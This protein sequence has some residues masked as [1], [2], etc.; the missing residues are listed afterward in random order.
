MRF[1]LPDLIDGSLSSLIDETR[2]YYA[3]RPSGSGPRSLTELTEVR[4]QREA[5]LP[6]P[7]PGVYTLDVRADG[8]SVSVRVIEPSS[9]VVNGIFLHIH[10][11]GFYL[12]SA[13]RD[14]VR[15]REFA[16]GAGMVVVSVDYRLAPEAPWPAAPDDCETAARWLLD[17]AERRFG[18]NQLAIGGFSAGATL[19]VVT[20]LRLRDRG[21][22][23]HFTSATLQ[24]GTYDL[25]GTTPAGRLIADEYFLEAYIG[26]VDDRTHPDISPVFADLAG[27]PSTLIVVGE[28]DVLLEDNLAFATRLAAANNDVDLRVYP[29]A[30]HGFSVHPTAMAAAARR[31]IADW[32]GLPRAMPAAAPA[33]E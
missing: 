18:T 1:G 12:D 30:P 8:H 11:G 21:I 15:N 33:P 4:A 32:I 2:N 23:R 17:E 9:G 16:D 27:L 31:D 14:D 29:Q 6:P 19:A 5:Q 24:F 25:S 22:A 26:H 28:K 20:L 10:G 7:D 3:T 13:A